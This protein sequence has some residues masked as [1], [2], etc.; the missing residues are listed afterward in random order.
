MNLF[1]E[2]FPYVDGKIDEGVVQMRYEASIINRDAKLIR[3]LYKNSL[4]KPN[5]INIDKIIKISNL[6]KEFSDK[7]NEL[8]EFFNEDSN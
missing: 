3:C 8:F 4:V 2:S 1:T 6:E 5:K 7:F